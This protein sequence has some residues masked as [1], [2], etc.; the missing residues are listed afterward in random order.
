[1][2]LQLCILLRIKGLRDGCHG[3][4]CLLPRSQADGGHY[5]HA[6]SV[7]FARRPVVG[8][9]VF[10]SPGAGI[11]SSA[12]CTCALPMTFRVQASSFM[13]ARKPNVETF[14]IS[15]SSGLGLLCKE[16]NHDLFTSK[17]IRS[18]L[19][20]CVRTTFTVLPR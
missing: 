18:D 13:Y 20:K 3:S 4:E 9:H 15:D 1:M 10:C 5:V 2:T 19:A 6:M 12:S 11:S 14:I 16:H 17:K 8:D 7:L